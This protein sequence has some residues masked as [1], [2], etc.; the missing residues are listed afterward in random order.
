MEGAAADQ[1]AKPIV[2]S[3]DESDSGDDWRPVAGRRRSVVDG[4]NNCDHNSGDASSG[5]PAAN[6]K[7]HKGND[8]DDEEEEEAEGDG[9]MMAAANPFYDANA[10][11]EDEA[12]VYKNLRSGTL[13]SVRVR[14]ADTRST[15]AGGAERKISA[16]ASSA[17]P[18]P[19][20]QR[21]QDD[22]RQLKVLKPRH[23]DAVLSCPCC[24]NIVCMDC[25]RHERYPDQF[26]A[27]F[28]VS[29]SIIVKWSERLRY[30]DSLR[31]LVEVESAASAPSSLSAAAGNVVPPD[32]AAGTTAAAPTAKEEGAAADGSDDLFFRVCCA[33]C[34]TQVAALDMND[35]VY[36]FFGCLASS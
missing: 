36:H 5:S 11:D 10:D 15:S 6:N 9:A 2:T 32:T 31:C 26:R 16:A 8:D 3:C 29:M 1:A 12:Y 34:E 13:E 33:N 27:M 18:S 25:Q 14:T 21:E 4:N 17:D 24:F 30:D 19:Q 35:E 20:Q 23:S 28:V 7:K 22:V